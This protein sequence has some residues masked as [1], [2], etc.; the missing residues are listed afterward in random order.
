[1][2]YVV[3]PP[4]FN[5]LTASDAQ[6][7]EYQFPSRPSD[8]TALAQWERFMSIATPVAPPA[9][10]A[11]S[12]NVRNA[13][14]YSKNWAGY[15]NKNNTYNTAVA[16][17]NEPQISSSTCTSPAESVWTGLGGVNNSNALGQAGTAYNEP[18]LG[19]HQSW[20]EELPNG[21]IA[22]PIYGVVGTSMAI[23]VQDIGSGQMKYFIENS[24][25]QYVNPTYFDNNKDDSTVDFIVEAP[26]INGSIAPLANFGTVPFT[27]ATDGSQG[28]LSAN[29]YDETI[30]I[31]Q[32]GGNAAT[33]SSLNGNSFSVAWNSC[34]TYPR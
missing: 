7:A 30:M 14:G 9:T 34:V 3:P 10:L 12:P 11:E 1:M 23:Y 19:N 32:G 4:D 8:P 29:P 26:F 2:K 27:Q 31:A 15:Y 17:Y 21:P 5:P 25:G 13:V 33:P 20:V 28:G 18:G 24:A 22:Q 6:L 16:Y